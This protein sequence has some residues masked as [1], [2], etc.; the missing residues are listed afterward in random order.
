MDE[1]KYWPKFVS[2]WSGHLK[3]ETYFNIYCTFDN[4]LHTLCVD[5]APPKTE[6]SVRE[7]G[8]VL[9]TVIYHIFQ[10]PLTK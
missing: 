5:L 4:A 10:V 3:V 2:V 1:L 7:K 8:Q 6:Q 9:H